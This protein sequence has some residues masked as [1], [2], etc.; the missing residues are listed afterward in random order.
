M[1]VFPASGTAG[2]WGNARTGIVT[3]TMSPAAAASPPAAAMGGFPAQ[4][5]GWPGPPPHASTYRP[6]PSPAPG[7]T[8]RRRRER[9]GRSTGSCRLPGSRR[10]PSPSRGRSAWG[11]S[12]PGRW[13][14]A[15]WWR[16]ARRKTALPARRGRWRRSPRRCGPG[17][18][19]CAHRRR[20][21]PG[22]PLWPGGPGSL[23][24]SRA[25]RCSPLRPAAFRF[26]PAAEEVVRETLSRGT[27]HRGRRRRSPRRGGPGPS[28]AARPLPASGPSPGRRHRGDAVRG[29]R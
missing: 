3:T 4:G 14:C 18:C 1:T 29:S 15:R 16:S 7:G 27:R 28:A 11:G 17:G 22:R 19:H 2:R 24:R 25:S 6:G 13:C 9:A 23:P 10:S 5:P 20:E 12:L 8:R 26:P 21:G